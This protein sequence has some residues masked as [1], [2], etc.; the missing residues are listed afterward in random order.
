MQ[1]L[2]NLKIIM[3]LFTS[4]EHPITPEIAFD[5]YRDAVKGLD[6]DRIL[7]AIPRIDEGELFDPA[8]GSEIGRFRQISCMGGLVIMQQCATN[9]KTTSLVLSA[10]DVVR[11]ETYRATLTRRSAIFEYGHWTE[12]MTI[13]GQPPLTSKF[14]LEQN[15]KRNK[16]QRKIGYAVTVGLFENV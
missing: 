12:D 6:N 8:T 9:S 5:Y 4:K 3:L 11:R 10:N 2:Y 13:F 7:P 15:K 16:G 14:R 1:I